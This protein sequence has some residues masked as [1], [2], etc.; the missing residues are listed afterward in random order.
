MHNT[1]DIPPLTPAMLRL[2]NPIEDFI[3]AIRAA[4]LPERC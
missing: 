4:P 2:E 3:G 1:Y